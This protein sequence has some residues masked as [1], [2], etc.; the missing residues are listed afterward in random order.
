MPEVLV[1]GRPARIRV[2]IHA[3]EGSIGPPCIADPRRSYRRLA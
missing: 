3:P 1:V 2:Q